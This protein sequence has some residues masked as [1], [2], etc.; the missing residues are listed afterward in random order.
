M[1]DFAQELSK[2]FPGFEAEV[3]DD[4]SLA[5]VHFFSQKDNGLFDMEGV[6]ADSGFVP[7]YNL[8]K[9]VADYVLWLKKNR[10]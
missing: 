6:R 10:R 9:A 7:E 1:L 8:E 2:Y 5:N 4:P 3:C